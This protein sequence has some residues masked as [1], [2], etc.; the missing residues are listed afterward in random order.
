M[1]APATHGNVERWT[2]ANPCPVCGGCDGD[3]RG[4]GE[5]CYGFRSSDQKYL[6]C[7]REEYAGPLTHHRNG[8]TFAHRAEGKCK[9]G[10]THGSEVPLPPRVP[11]ATRKSEA[12]KARRSYASLDEVKKIKGEPVTL[13]HVYEAADGSTLGA[14]I[15]NAKK[16]YQ[17]LSYIDGRWEYTSRNVKHVPYKLPELNDAIAAG[18]TVYIVEGEKD[19]DAVFAAGLVA[20]CNSGGALKWTV[21]HAKHLLGAERVCIVAD[22]DEHER[23][24][25]HA[26]IVA[27]TLRDSGAHLEFYEAA[28]GKDVYD[29]LA[30]ELNIEQ[31]V[32]LDPEAPPLKRAPV[33]SRKPIRASAIKP[34][35][36]E[37]LWEGYVPKGKVT[38]VIGDGGLGK[39]LVLLDIAARISKGRPMPYEMF[40]I[41]REPRSVLLLAAEDDLADTVVP[42]LIAAGADTDRI[43]MFSIHDGISFPEDIGVIESAIKDDMPSLVIIDPIMGFL[44]DEVKSGI[45][46][47]VRRNV[48]GPITDVASRYG[49]AVMWIRHVNKDEKAQSSNRGTGSTAWRNAARA[50]LA[51]GPDH[52][53]PEQQRRFMAQAKTNLGLPAPVLAY[54]IES[55]FGRVVRD[56]VAIENPRIGQPVVEWLGTA[57]DVNLA[58]VIGPPPKPSG[59]REGTKT[60]ACIQEI[61]ELLSADPGEVRSTTLDEMLASHGFKQ[62]VIESAKKHATISERVSDGNG[63]K[64]HWIVR[65]RPS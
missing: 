35:N 53:D 7:T 21:E 65:L 10:N 63:G 12:K 36:V 19:V 61:R 13:R 25:Q 40:D 42:R 50:G 62:G 34:E 39:S 11:E 32:K 45:D 9:C 14:V 52:E 23:G 57:D 15:R 60:A 22:K 55:T 1:T 56:G 46:S 48:A 58:D 17:Q 28:Q 41:E 29:H 26:R 16:N 64:G 30:A 33:A 54:K 24:Y 38:D 49:A 20:T 5:R 6:H 43:S 44:G 4:K 8:D 51:F 2:R 31:L 47:S 3:R 59:P 18:D 37:W 27:E